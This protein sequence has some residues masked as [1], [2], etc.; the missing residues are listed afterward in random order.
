MDNIPRCITENA[1]CSTVVASGDTFCRR[2][3][4]EELEYS[5]RYKFKDDIAQNVLIK[6]IG[7][8]KLSP[9]DNAIH[10]RVCEEDEENLRN[11]IDFI[12]RTPR[13]VNISFKSK[14]LATILIG[15]YTNIDSDLTNLFY[16]NETKNEDDFKIGTSLQI[17]STFK[18]QETAWI[19]IDMPYTNITVI[20]L[21]TVLFV[22]FCVFLIMSTFTKPVA[23]KNLESKHQ[24]AYNIATKRKRKKT[25]D[26]K[27]RNK[28]L[29][30]EEMV[31]IIKDQQILLNKLSDHVINIQ[32]NLVDTNY[33]TDS[34]LSF[35]NLHLYRDI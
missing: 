32:P 15:N 27:N 13:M 35:N 23:I 22:S 17:F 20:L 11:C 12:E 5:L 16:L 30:K 6:P 4:C 2:G 7:L 1:F 3:I 10:G 9:L 18:R 14:A 33:E 8:S 29:S 25:E 28:S 24:N 26:K 19:P 34:T 31:H 21:A